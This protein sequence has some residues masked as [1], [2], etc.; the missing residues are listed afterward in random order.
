MGWQN[1]HLHEFIVGKTHYR[2]P[3]PD[4]DSV[5]QEIIN[6]RRVLLRKIAPREGARFEYLYDFGD[7][8]EHTVV[9][10]KILSSQ[11]GVSYP[12]CLAGERACPPE[13]SGGDVDHMIEVL[14]DPTDPEHDEIQAWVGTD[15]DPEAFS[16][17]AVNTLLSTTP[18]QP[19]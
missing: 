12:L 6:E 2:D 15:Y 5:G 3:N 14:R 7:N 10:E 19:C 8:W 4:D 1:S 11:P 18:P 9:V 17:A 16:V 13:D